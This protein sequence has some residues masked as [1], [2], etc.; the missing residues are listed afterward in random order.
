[1]VRYNM[2]DDYPKLE[3]KPTFKKNK[4]KGNNKN[5]SAHAIKIFDEVSD[6]T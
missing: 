3:K 6:L 4:M 2:G 1:M 5:K